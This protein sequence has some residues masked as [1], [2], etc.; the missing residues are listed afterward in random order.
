MVVFEIKEKNERICS[1]FKLFVVVDSFSFSSR[2]QEQFRS[3]SVYS[4][5]KLCAFYSTAQ[6]FIVSNKH[7][8][9]YRF[10]YMCSTIMRKNGISFWKINSHRERDTSTEHI[11]M[12][13][14]T[15]TY[16]ILCS[17]EAGVRTAQVFCMCKWNNET[18]THRKNSLKF[19]MFFLIF[20]FFLNFCTL[21]ERVRQKRN[22][23]YFSSRSSDK[24]AAA[25][26]KRKHRR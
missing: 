1:L 13:S 25:K 2:L 6:T 19:T 14:T 26:L 20:N 7:T 4:R 22:I 5:E 16:N 12:W 23:H 10:F 24:N 17:S 9:I 11:L 15:V 8:H 21:I 18:H 3:L